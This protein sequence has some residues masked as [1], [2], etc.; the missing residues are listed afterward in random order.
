MR[1]AAAR[2]VARAH[3]VSATFPGHF[4]P[5]ATAVDRGLEQGPRLHRGF[6]SRQKNIPEGCRHTPWSLSGFSKTYSSDG[7]GNDT[8][9]FL[10]TTTK[11]VVFDRH[12]HPGNV[13]YVEPKL[14]LPPIGP[15][16]VLVKW[17]VSPV[18]PSDINTVQ[19]VYP[20][21]PK[22][23]PAIG[24]SEGVGEVVRFGSDVD[25]TSLAGSS[26]Y[27]Y[28][29]DGDD[30]G[31]VN[32]EETRSKNIRVIPDVPGLGTW[33]EFAVVPARSL[34]IIPSHIPDDTAA[35]LCVNLP[36]ALRLLEDFVDLKN[37]SSSVAINAPTSAVGRAVV[38]MCKAFDVPV[39]CS[40]RARDTEEL[41]I[42]DAER[43]KQ[44]GACYVVLD[45]L[46]RGG[47]RT[48][49]ARDFLKTLP[50]VRLALNCVGGDSSLILSGV[51][52]EN[53]VIVTYGGMGLSPVYI[54]TGA[55]IFI[56][57][58]AKGFWLTRW[59][60]C[61]RDNEARKKMYFDK[62]E[63]SE[64][65]LPDGIF[66]GIGDDECPR[67]AMYRSLFRMIGRGE[68]VMAIARKVGFEDFVQAIDQGKGKTALWMT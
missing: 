53:G 26:L 25:E 29:D 65:I 31:N 23:F 48:R 28:G 8:L 46:K 16:D 21:L 9:S 12:G 66:S 51:L 1:A 11:A 54:P 57:I 39:V 64:E 58:N 60:Q 55:S 13:L 43:L 34:R 50:P 42:R 35:Q 56:N 41:W 38:Q 68:L 27:Y 63:Q 37:N 32:S 2:L 24:G 4:C 61:V 20:I 62:S 10:P 36:T 45:D 33:R 47:F 59:N 15:D 6:S 22:T 19:G 18:N 67:D 14:Q 3:S 40:L 30:G 44:L 17:K 5:Y 52:T 7:S 49:E